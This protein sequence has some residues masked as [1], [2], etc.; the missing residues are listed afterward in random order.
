MYI[1]LA[2]PAHCVRA[3]EQGFRPLTRVQF[4]ALATTIKT[5]RSL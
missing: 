4:D 2:F 5:E 1:D 3:A